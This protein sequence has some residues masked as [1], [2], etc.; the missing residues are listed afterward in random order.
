VRL[1]HNQRRGLCVR[2]SGYQWQRRKSCRG[3]QHET[4][5]CHDDL[6]SP[7]KILATNGYLLNNPA[8]LTING[9]AL[10]RIVAAFKIKFVFILNT[11]SGHALLFIGHSDDP[12]PANS[13]Y[14]G[15]SRA[16]TS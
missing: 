15:L 9:Q 1:R 3:K 11:K 16:T 13:S 7:G 10:G 2:W 4:K 12:G 14:P 8:S 6:W 5:F